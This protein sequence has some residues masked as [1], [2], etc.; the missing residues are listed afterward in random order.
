MFSHPGDLVKSSGM[1]D[2]APL[3]P[4]TSSQLRVAGGFALPGQLRGKW[5]SWQPPEIRAVSDVPG[6]FEVRLID[7][8]GWEDE[9]EQVEETVSGD[10]GRR[11]RSGGGASVGS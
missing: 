5:H 8:V 2:L 9:P 3:V 1:D 6:G 10:L 4:L 11:E 7:V